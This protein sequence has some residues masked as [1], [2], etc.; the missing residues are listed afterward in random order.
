[1]PPPGACRPTWPVPWS[2]A[3]PSTPKTTRCCPLDRQAATAGIKREDYVD[4]YRQIC[5]HRG[6]LFG[7]PTTPNASALI[8]NKKWIREAG[9]DPEQPPR[10]VAEAKEYLPLRRV[11]DDF[12]PQHPDPCIHKHVEPAN[13]PNSHLLPGATT[14]NEYNDA[15]TRIRTGSRTVAEASGGV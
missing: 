13:S 14:W 3:S 11:S 10:S 6:V 7:V 9:L 4:V 15:L 1:M 2:E 5:S 8:W 12:Y